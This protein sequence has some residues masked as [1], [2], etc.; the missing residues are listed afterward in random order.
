MIT[1][2]HK[3]VSGDTT[4]RQTG[5]QKKKKKDYFAR[6]KSNTKKLKTTCVERQKQ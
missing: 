2:L 3:M 5:N 6:G 1:Q 4:D